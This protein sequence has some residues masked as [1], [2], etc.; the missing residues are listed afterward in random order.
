[1]NAITSII[2]AFVLLLLVLQPIAAQLQTLPICPE[3]TA[4]DSSEV[5]V[6]FDGCPL[7]LDAEGL[8][9]LADQFLETYN[10]I[11]SQNSNGLCDPH[12]RE[13]VFVTAVLSPTFEV[14]FDRRKLGSEDDA[15]EDAAKA[16]EDA[17][18]DAED[19][20]EDAAK[21]AEDAAEDAAKAAEDAAED[22]A[23]AAEDA[24]EDAE[25]AAEDAADAAEDAAEDAADA[26]EDPGA[27][28]TGSNR[29]YGAVGECPESFQIRFEI[30]ARCRGCDPNTVTLFDQQQAVN[31]FEG[32]SEDRRL[33]QEVFH[34]SVRGK[35]KLQQECQCPI[36]P[37]YRAVTEMEMEDAFDDLLKEDESVFRLGLLELRVKDLIEI[38]KVECAPIKTNFDTEVEIEFGTDSTDPIVPAELLT[39]LSGKFQTSY[40]TLTERFCDPL[41]RQVEAVQVVSLSAT[42]AVRRELQGIGNGNGIANGNANGNANRGQFGS[43]PTFSF[44]FVYKFKFLL[45]G[46][47]RGCPKNSNLFVSIPAISPLYFNPLFMYSPF[48]SFNFLI[49]MTLVEDVSSW[50]STR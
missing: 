46:V 2:A 24:A 20:A 18:K 47:C 4:F 8:K 14:D 39:A 12:F 29:S 33:H 38:G 5:V 25:D 27:T 10:F 15:A 1:M 48:Y 30:S 45:T 11:N 13:I 43:P 17:A 40:N 34:H 31:Y 16:A 32:F 37:Q 22:A 42:P 3:F 6:E 9:V 41:F 49:R 26:A 19:A 21:D 7:D 50:Q 44:N 36:N 23:K 28:T 35:R